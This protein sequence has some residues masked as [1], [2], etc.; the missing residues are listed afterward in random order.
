MYCLLK[1]TLR[2][3]ISLYVK[4]GNFQPHTCKTHYFLSSLKVVVNYN[5]NYRVYS[6]LITSYASLIEEVLLNRTVWYLKECT[7]TIL[8]IYIYIY[9]YIYTCVYIYICMCVF[10]IYYTKIANP[11][12]PTTII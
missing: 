3:H 4:I 1:S 10:H 2:N 6:S 8:Y 12:C 7:R 9:I 11:N 5:D